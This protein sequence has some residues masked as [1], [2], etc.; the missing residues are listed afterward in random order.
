MTKGIL[1]ALTGSLCL[2]ALSPA[3]ADL[4]DYGWEP[5]TTRMAV[6]GGIGGGGDTLV[7]VQ[8]SNGD[9]KT[10]HAGDG[11]YGDL[12]VQH[13]FAD[14]AWSIKATAGF[15]YAAASG[16]NATVS[17]ERYPL[18]LL[19]IYSI[20]RSHIGFGLTEHLAPRVDLD[21]L[22]P[23]ADFSS[24]TG[25]VLQYQYWLFGAR[26]TGISYKPSGG[27]S[28][29]CTIKGNSLSLFFNYVF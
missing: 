10:I 18:D 2:L 9:T 21:G 23:N 17:F 13:N 8:Y 7:T 27:C 24:A 1:A 26:L 22:G 28:S 11:L 16:S 19:A 5:G 25:V 20:G 14:S 3:R 4:G 12:G 15:D 29:G 6:D